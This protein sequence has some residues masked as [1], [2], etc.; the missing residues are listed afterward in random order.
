MYPENF[1]GYTQAQL[2]LV[3]EQLQNNPNGISVLSHSQRMSLLANLTL[4]RA[5]IND[6]I[7]SLDVTIQTLGES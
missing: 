1:N 7:Y 5:N 6:T 4:L 2:L 3:V